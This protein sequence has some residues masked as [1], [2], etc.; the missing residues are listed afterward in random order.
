MR[1][2][3]AIILGAAAALGACSGAGDEAGSGE[4]DALTLTPG[5]WTASAEQASYADD[6]GVLLASFHCDAET[7]ELVLEMP[8]GFADGARPAILMRA[9]DFMHGVDPVEMRGTAEGTVRLARA[10]VGGPLMGAVR[11]FPVP[12]TIEADGAPPVM[13]ETDS[14]L[15][16]F[17]ESCAAASSTGDSAE[18][19]Q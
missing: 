8:G 4:P 9:G 15:Q 19:A 11:A 18:P 17:F 6:G 5:A 10:P 7:A 3:S 16:E 12:L 13:I 14:V 1:F 2:R